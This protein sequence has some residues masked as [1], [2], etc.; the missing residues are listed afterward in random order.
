MIS[1]FMLLF[2]WLQMNWRSLGNIQRTPAQYLPDS[3]ETKIRE[4]GTVGPSA[5]QSE[6]QRAAN[7][8]SQ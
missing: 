3:Y 5:Q 4:D 2:K 6:L 7:S 1:F 8:G